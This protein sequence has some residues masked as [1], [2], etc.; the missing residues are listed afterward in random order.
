MLP[1]LPSAPWV[2]RDEADRPSVRLF[3]RALGGRDLALGLGCVLALRKGRRARGW[4]EAG[5]L[6]DAGDTLATL[7]A[8][9]SLPRRSRVGILALTIGAALAG[10][11]LAP[12]VD[13]AHTNDAS[14]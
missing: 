8:F 14:R 1:R 13:A 10:G 2:G 7:L 9:S 4:V 5:A 11:A 3:A 12:L 6:A